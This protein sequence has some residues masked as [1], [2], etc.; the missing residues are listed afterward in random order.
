MY[1]RQDYIA[2]KTSGIKDYIGIFAV[3]SGINVELYEKIFEKDEDDY[4]G[5]MIK[6]IT[7]RLAEAFAEY[8]HDR[9]RKDLW[10]YQPKELS[11]ED[12][13][14]EKYQG[15]RP[16]PGYPVC[17]EHTVK[18]DIFTILQTDEIGMQ[19]TDSM[20]MHP[21]SSVSGFYF[22]HPDAKYF[23]VD[24]IDE[25]QLEDMASRRSVPTKQLRKWLGPNLR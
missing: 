12:M 18:K 13:I 7:D 4:N 3:T 6:A 19:L 8:M 16:A 23:S 11:T 25:D 21:A 15:I 10:G 1:K 14:Q 24:K 17:P 9:V 2:P 22:A 5:I 20:A